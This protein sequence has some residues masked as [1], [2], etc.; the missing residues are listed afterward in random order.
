M[1]EISLVAFRGVALT[2]VA[3]VTSAT[4]L[5][6]VVLSQPEALGTTTLWAHVYA[7]PGVVAGC[8]LVLT[9]L[10]AVES[11]RYTHIIRQQTAKA[12]LLMQR[13]HGARGWQIAQADTLYDGAAE[14]EVN[15]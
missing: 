3:F 5:T 7:V 4:A 9:A 10:L 14:Q 13:L 15:I 12:A 2:A 1:S 6:A 8:V 11:P